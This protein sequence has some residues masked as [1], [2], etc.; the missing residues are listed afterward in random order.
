[1][2]SKCYLSKGIDRGQGFIAKRRTVSGNDYR[3]TRERGPENPSLPLEPETS[4]LTLQGDLFYILTYFIFS[5][6]TSNPSVFIKP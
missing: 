1:M 6:Q 4:S 5:F 2:P 3:S